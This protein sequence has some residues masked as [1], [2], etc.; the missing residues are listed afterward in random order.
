M[1]ALHDRADDELDVDAEDLTPMGDI[2]YEESDGVETDV[3]VELFL[4]RMQATRFS[5]A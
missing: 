3:E 5:D 1:K 2:E 4:T